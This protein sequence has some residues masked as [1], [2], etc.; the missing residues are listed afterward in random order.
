MF[1]QC[2]GDGVMSSCT[3]CITLLNSEDVPTMWSL[4][5]SQ[6]VVLP[7]ITDVIK[8]SAFLNFF[9]AHVNSHAL[10]RTVSPTLITQSSLCTKSH[11][12][13]TPDHYINNINFVNN[14][15]N[16]PM[17]LRF[18]KNPIIFNKSIKIFPRSV[19]E[20]FHSRHPHPETYNWRFL[21]AKSICEGSEASLIKGLIGIGQKLLGGG[22]GT[23]YVGSVVIFSN[24]ILGG[25]L[26]FLPKLREGH[27]FFGKVSWSQ[28]PS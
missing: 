20:K 28:Y 10:P 8:C 25:S 7:D 4:S 27:I 6:I 24:K 3:V 16:W 13:L 23:I 11:A 17:N 18:P 9:P 19:M 12:C 5:I 22:G 15:R 2:S 14:R 1:A 26:F 21:L